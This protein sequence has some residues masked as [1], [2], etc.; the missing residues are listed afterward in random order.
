[1]PSSTYAS[2]I[3]KIGIRVTLMIGLQPSWQR[4]P[5]LYW[6][7][8]W[9]LY[10]HIRLFTLSKMH[11]C[12]PGCAS[13]RPLHHMPMRRGIYDSPL[14]SAHD[15]CSKI[16]VRNLPDPSGIISNVE[17]CQIGCSAS[18][19]CASSQYRCTATC[20]PSFQQ[21]V[22]PLARSVS[23]PASAV[24]GAEMSSMTWTMTRG[25]ATSVAALT[26]PWGPSATAP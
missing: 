23:Q 18:P 2:S 11:A 3:N 22:P 20:D 21:G 6:Q 14:A 13:D 26:L 24:A 8:C 1:M 17:R 7:R 12:H 10:V 9:N 4:V 19:G 25:A 15:C 5:L 16:H